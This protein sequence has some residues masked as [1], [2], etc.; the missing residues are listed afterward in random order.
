MLVTSVLCYKSA[1]FAWL[2]D[3]RAQIGKKGENKL[4]N[5][6]IDHSFWNDLSAIKQIIRPIYDAQKM[7]ESDNSTLSKVVL[8]WQKLEIEL[9]Q[10]SIIYLSLIRGFVQPG[11]PFLIWLQKQTTELHFAALLLDPVSLLKEPAQVEI[12]T[13]IRFLLK[14]CNKDNTKEVHKS[15]FEFCSYSSVFGA[16]HPALMHYDNPIAY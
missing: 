12:D 4:S 9:C 16:S 10:L 1:L 6:I 14:R 3:P 11:G 5:I 2:G 7:S 8:C 15:F 13:A